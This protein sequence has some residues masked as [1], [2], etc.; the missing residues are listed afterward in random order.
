MPEIEHIVVLMMENHSFDN[1]LGMV[2]YQVPGRADGRRLH[3]A[4]TGSST[5]CQPRCRRRRRSMRAR[6]DL[7]VPAGRRARP[8]PGTRRHESYDNGRN[9]GFV[10]ASGP[11]AMRYWDQHDL[12]FTYSLVQHFPIG[13]R[14][15]CSVL[16]QTYPNRRFLFTGTASGTDRRPT[17]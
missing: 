1:L 5:N 14:Y 11:I 3:A 8:R 15:F 6:A 17:A 10:P 9:D 12:P 16:A 4:R 13:E 7:A 2:P